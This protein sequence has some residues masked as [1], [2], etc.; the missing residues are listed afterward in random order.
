VNGSLM[1]RLALETGGSHFPVVFKQ[2]QEMYTKQVLQECYQVFL[3]SQQSSKE[4]LAID[5]L[6]DIQK[7]FEIDL[8]TA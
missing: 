6:F 4:Y 1:N 5:F 8:K 2:H 3:D 7:H